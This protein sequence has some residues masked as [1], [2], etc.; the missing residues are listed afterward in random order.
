MK[1]FKNT[2]IAALLILLVMLIPLQTFGVPGIS[3]QFSSFGDAIQSSL[4]SKT[5]N[6]T[7][8]LDKK[9][10]SSVI[11]RTNS[12]DIHIGRIYLSYTVSEYNLLLK[13]WEDADFSNRFTYVRING[14]TPNSYHKVKIYAGKKYVG[15]YTFYTKP[16]NIA[17]VKAN[18][19]KKEVVLT[20]S[21]RNKYHTEIFKKSKKV[22]MD[23]KEEPIET[24]WKRICNTK[25]AKFTD[26]DI[27]EDT[28]YYYKA[29]Y[30]CT[31]AGKKQYS[32]DKFFDEIYIPLEINNIL[33]TN[34]YIIVRQND[35]LNSTIP[36][37]YKDNGKTIGSSGC[38]VCSSLMIIRNMTTFEPKLESYTEALIEK[39][40][41]A[42]YGSNIYVI[43]DYLKDEYKLHHSYTKD[44]E[45]LKAHLKNGN[46]AIAHVG[47]N[48][49][50]ARSGHFVVVA[51]IVKD[52]EENERAVI[53]DPT[54][55]KA[56]YD[57]QRRVDMGIA[58]SDD[59]IVTAP[60]ETLL[61]DC[62][63][64][65]FTLFTAEKSVKK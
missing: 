12:A 18:P 58:Y 54:F 7:G 36:Y 31:N 10:K 30:V 13:K 59:G 1:R 44:V 33:E 5:E 23:G 9:S 50:F 20:W 42:P 40:A 15:T 38:G 6:T 34:G 43:A 14:L 55:A 11:T 48:K 46:M 45:K 47:V 37:P 8:K 62:K 60:F 29:R 51:G 53:L 19:S 39:G 24:E 28:Y 17:T 3:E 61:A 64:E 63:D 25:E 21:N 41:R 4:F 49:Y 52:E 2:L 56:K 27:E 57:V 35:P 32:D 26:T 16:E 22:D 65:Y